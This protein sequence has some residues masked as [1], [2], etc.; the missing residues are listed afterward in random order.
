MMDI[1]EL[2]KKVQAIMSEVDKIKKAHE[3]ELEPF[4]DKVKDLNELFLD[5]KLLD[6]NGETVKV[7]AS[8]IDS[9]G[10]V[11]KVL[12]RYQ[13]CVFNFLGNATV[14]VLQEGRKRKTEISYTSHLGYLIIK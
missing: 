6:K 2:N 8:L 1:D 14:V 12:Y 7:G 5:G 11:F 10:R 13:Q 4:H 3:V 9:K